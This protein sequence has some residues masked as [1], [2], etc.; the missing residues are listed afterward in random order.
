MP[1]AAVLVNPDPGNGMSSSLLAA[2]RAI[3]ADAT[4]AV[5]LADKPFV[6]RETL[7]FCEREFAA[8]GCDVLVPELLGERGHPVYFSPKARVRLEALPPGDTLHR[9]RDD[10]ALVKLSVHCND[11]GILLDLDTPEA[12]RGAERRLTGA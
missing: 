1:W 8:H 2:H 11:R 5:L 12:W 9:V 10:P 7:E 6:R 3:D 4:L